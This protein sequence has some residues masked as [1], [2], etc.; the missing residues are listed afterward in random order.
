MVCSTILGSSFVFGVEPWGETERRFF[1]AWWATR[2]AGTE[3][4]P[5]MLR[6]FA[7]GS[8]L[9]GG[10]DHE[11]HASHFTWS[12][13]QQRRRGA[14]PSSVLLLLSSSKSLGKC[15]HRSRP[16]FHTQQRARFMEP[17]HVPRTSSGETIIPTDV[18]VKVFRYMG[19]MT[20]AEA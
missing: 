9:P 14:L 7:A 4:R 19:M 5:Y 8:S 16:R 13:D 18:S 11:L 6:C 20:L 1:F 12:P 15:Q 17:I 3:G 10:F 2:T